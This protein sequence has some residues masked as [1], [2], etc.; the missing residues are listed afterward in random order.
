M[1]RASFLAISTLRTGG[2]YGVASRAVRLPTPPTVY[3]SLAVAAL[4]C[5]ALAGFEAPQAIEAVVTGPAATFREDGAFL[6]LGVDGRGGRPL[7]AAFREGYAVLLAAWL[8][9]T[10]INVIWGRVLGA[11]SALAAVFILSVVLSTLR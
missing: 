7:H 10:G 1:A 9:P 6:A 11:L 2:C 5:I 4:L 8:A 3:S